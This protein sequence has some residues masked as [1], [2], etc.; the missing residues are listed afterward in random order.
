MKRILLTL[1]AAAGLAGSG[2]SAGDPNDKL[3]GA[4]AAES[5]GQ[6][7][8]IH[9]DFNAPNQVGEY[10]AMQQADKH[11]SDPT[12][13]V[14]AARYHGCTKITYAA[15]GSILSSRG[16]KLNGQANA[17]TLYKNGSSALGVANYGGRAPESLLASTSAMAKMFDVFVAAAPEIQANLGAS[18]AC[19][20]VTIADATGKFSKDGLSCLMGTLATD[21]HVAVADQAVKDAVAGGATVTQGVQVAI[22]A[23]LEAAHTCE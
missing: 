8:S 2:C 14:T 5:R 13:G 23:L 4:A 1:V 18:A 6:A 9:H 15:L 22:A 19:S 3:G 12:G 10:G 17:L 11:V 20:G 16:A 7:L 21:D